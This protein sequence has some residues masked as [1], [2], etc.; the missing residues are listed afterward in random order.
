MFNWGSQKIKKPV[1]VL[2]FTHLVA[3]SKEPVLVLQTRYPERECGFNKRIYTGF[4]GLVTL[5][6]NFF[7]LRHDCGTAAFASFSFL[8]ISFFSLQS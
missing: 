1:D 6:N 4:N 5:L 3:L 7:A 2:V 8:H